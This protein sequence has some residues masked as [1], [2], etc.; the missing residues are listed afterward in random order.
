MNA[1]A[2]NTRREKKIHDSSNSSLMMQSFS[3]LAHT[4]CG[5]RLR[6]GRMTKSMVVPIGGEVILSVVIG[7]VI[8][9]FVDRSKQHLPHIAIAG[10]SVDNVPMVNSARISCDFLV[11]WRQQ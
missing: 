7:I 9:P 10:F 1:V 2:R 8:E 5:C 3:E 4:I 6:A 11:P